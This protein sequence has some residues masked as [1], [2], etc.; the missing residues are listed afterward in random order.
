MGPVVLF[1]KSF[2]QSLSVDESVWF[3][4]FFYPIICPIFYV[5][6][7]A[8]LEKAVGQGR[9]PE[10][11]VG[12]IAE[13]TP[14]RHGGPCA[15]HKA[16]CLNSLHGSNIPM[17][18][19]IPIKSGRLVRTDEGESG[20][21]VEETP[22]AQALSHWQKREFLKLERGLAKVWRTSLENLDLLAVAA[23]IRAMG[24]DEK[25]CKSI[26]EAKQI[27]DMIIKTWKPQDIIKL[28]SIFFGFPWHYEK[29][30]LERW[31][32]VG[33]PPL[34]IY[35]PYAAYVL[36]VELFSRIALESNL[37]STQ[38]QSN[39][40]DIAYLYYLPF[41]MLFVSSDKLHRRCT[42]LFLRSDQEFV[43]GEDLKGDLKKINDLYSKL[44][45]SEKDKGIMEFASTPPQ[46]DSFLVSQ[47]WDRH[48]RPWRQREPDSHKINPVV[49]KVLLEKMKRE[50][51]SRSL[52]PE[53]VDF[54]P[55]DAD[56]MTI[57]RKVRQRKG[58]WWQLPKDL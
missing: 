49:E 11:E 56:M 45:Q 35:A 15:Y 34:Y 46:E 55:K 37:I 32:Q 51:E 22:E 18:G 42:P 25:K 1:D 14:E 36:T 53:E 43:W 7:L 52:S 23:A 47:L 24:I 27:S 20:V 21:I 48:M 13:K 54:D 19:Q 30:I 28:A 3:D 9:T 29:R 16:L 50:I 12:R 2:L 39:R 26:A 58:S 6:T 33:F 44:P 40:A 38:R 10:Q 31:K 5:E 41:C 8:D 17:T 57:E 4:H